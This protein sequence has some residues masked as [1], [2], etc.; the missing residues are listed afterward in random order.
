MV[1]YWYTRLDIL[2]ATWKWGVC[3]IF[4]YIITD[5][6]LPIWLYDRNKE[7]L[8]YAKRPG[9]HLP[10]FGTLGEYNRSFKDKFCKIIHKR[11][12]TSFILNLIHLQR[13]YTESI[14]TLIPGYH[15]DGTTQRSHGNNVGATNIAHNV[16]RFLFSFCHRF[17]WA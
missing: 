6:S 17:L 10:K 9:N 14:C 4:I 1:K 2:Q 16:R 3:F 13:Y 7:A 12:N 15:M 11:K 5:I 8:R